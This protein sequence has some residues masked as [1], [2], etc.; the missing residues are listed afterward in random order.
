LI[1][2]N[3]RRPANG[4]PVKSGNSLG[5]FI[6]PPRQRTCAVA[7]RLQTWNYHAAHFNKPLPCTHSSFTFHAAIEPQICMMVIGMDDRELSCWL[8]PLS[9]RGG[10][11]SRREQKLKQIFGS[12]DKGVPPSG[13]SGKNSKISK[14]F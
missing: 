13:F 11:S 6:R 2:H 14:Q 1:H 4:L 3:S 8:S 10:A 12:K 9:S 5:D 7:I